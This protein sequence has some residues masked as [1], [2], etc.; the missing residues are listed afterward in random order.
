[1]NYPK[2]LKKG[3][4]SH[5]GEVNLQQGISA[6]GPPYNS[7]ESD[8]VDITKTRNRSTRQHNT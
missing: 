4:W 3:K 8:N 6:K 2:T 1:M 7:P 5:L